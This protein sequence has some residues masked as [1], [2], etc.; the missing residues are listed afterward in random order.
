[1]FALLGS[2]RSDGETAQ[3][4]RHVLKDRPHD[5]ADLCVQRLTPYSYDHDYPADDPFLE[6]IGRMIRHSTLIFATP[7]YWY[8]MSGVMKVFFDRLTDLLDLHKPMGRQLAGRHAYV[9]A[10]G[11]DEDLPDGFAV[12]FA[13]TCAYFAMSYGGVRYVYTGKNDRLRQSSW[14]EVEGHLR[15]PL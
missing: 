5:Y 6:I 9:L 11:T 1:M 7:V 8:G 3:A 12:P 14:A 10:T 15:I 13:R 4:L 2:A